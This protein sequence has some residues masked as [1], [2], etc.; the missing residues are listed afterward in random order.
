MYGDEDEEEEGKWI[1]LSV[2]YQ[3]GWNQLVLR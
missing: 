1:L 2:D 3:R